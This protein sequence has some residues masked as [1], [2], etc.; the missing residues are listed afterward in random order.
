MVEFTSR[1]HVARHM[2]TVMPHTGSHAQKLQLLAT[3]VCC[4]KPFAAT[5]AFSKIQHE[6]AIS[7]RLQAHVLEHTGSVIVS[8]NGKSELHYI[9]ALAYIEGE[10]DTL[11]IRMQLM[12]KGVGK[13]RR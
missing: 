9:P 1:C 11:D 10:I 13:Q 8:P 12:F 2:S 6:Q 5:I 7:T 3:S 4:L